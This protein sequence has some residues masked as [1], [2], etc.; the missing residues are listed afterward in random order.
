MRRQ[1]HAYRS[2]ARLQAAWGGIFAVLITVLGGCLKPAAAPDAPPPPQVTVACPQPAEVTDY[3]D[4]TGHIEAVKSVSVQ[5]M[6]SGR[7][8]KVLFK[9]GAMVEENQP[10]FLIDP[11]VFQAQYDQT[12]ANLNLAKAHLKR[13][14]LDL[15]RAKSLLPTKAIAQSDY[16]KAEGDRD[17]AAAAVA[18]AVASMNSAK[19]NLEYTTVRAKF[20]GR[21]SRQMVDPGNMVRANDTKLTTLVTN[22]QLYVYFDIDERTT[23]KI[24]RLFDAGELCAGGHSPLTINYGLADEEG[25]PRTASVNFVDNQIDMSTGTWRLR[26]KIDKPDPTLLPNM[27]LRVRVPLGTPYHALLV[28]EKALGTDQGQNFLYVIDKDNKAV[29]KQVTCAIACGPLPE[30]MR[31]I[32]PS[33]SKPE[34]KS[35]SQRISGS[36]NDDLKP[37]DR[38]VINGLQRIRAGQKVDPKE[39]APRTE[40]GKKEKQMAE[41][42][43]QPK[44]AER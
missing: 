27:F 2:F 5:A 39:E 31:A 15:Q 17:E 10:L 18:V 4:F 11:N 20:A 33:K 37:T 19:D 14:E 44:V 21:I 9:E 12:V 8:E 40:A 30:G 29:Y 32:L 26:A 34:D 41:T 22:D 36:G 23:I 35:S 13:L 3:E 42:P 25:F 7:L 28:P 16:D 38:F 1:N 43:P 6:V 24:R